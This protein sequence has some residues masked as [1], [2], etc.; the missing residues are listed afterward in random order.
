MVIM[1]SVI[2]RGSGRR[3]RRSARLVDISPL[4]RPP[5]DLGQLLPQVFLL[6]HLGKERRLADR[7][8]VTL[9][10]LR[11]RGRISMRRL[12]TPMPGT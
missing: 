1:V 3:R 2:L 6:D 7:R 11:G 8:V 12:V 5:V 4:F 10:P 9:F